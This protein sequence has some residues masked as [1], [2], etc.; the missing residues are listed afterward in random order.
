MGRELLRALQHG[1]H[2]NW[3]VFRAIYF[4]A[5]YDFFVQ[6]NCFVIIVQQ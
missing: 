5:S 2:L 3:T 6:S 4:W 1:N